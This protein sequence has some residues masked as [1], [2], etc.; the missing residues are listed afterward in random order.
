MPDW[1][2][3]GFTGLLSVATCGL[4]IVTG[5]MW[6]ETRKAVTLAI[7]RPWLFISGVCDLHERSAEDE[8]WTEVD[9]TIANHGE[10]PAIIESVK[11]Q[12]IFTK[13]HKEIPLSVEQ[14]HPLI[15]NPII[16]PGETRQNIPHLV[17]AGL[18]S[19]DKVI[20]LYGNRRASMAPQ[21]R[22]GREFIFLIKI[23]YRGISSRGHV[24]SGLWR[25]NY[26]VSRFEAYG[27][28]EKNY[29]K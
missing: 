17:P 11:C 18:L 14:D 16:G 3:A 29:A 26:S 15:V 27:G 20:Y 6:W 5:F 9:Y 23:Q 1:W 2:V 7:K 28:E 24:S 25:W 10:A 4:W 19:A 8:V 12:F 22:H 21:E 13:A